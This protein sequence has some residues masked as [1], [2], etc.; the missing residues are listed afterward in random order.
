MPSPYSAGGTF[1][2]VLSAN[3]ARP[4]PCPGDETRQ[5][6]ILKCPTDALHISAP[7][8]NYGDG[9]G[10]AGDIIGDSKHHGG[11]DKA[12]YAFAREELDYWSHTNQTAAPYPNGHFGENLTTV[13][14]HWAQAV[15]GQQVRI[16]STLL[17]VSVPRQ[18]CRTFALWIDRP[19]WLKTF[20]AHG[21]CGCYFRV[22]EAGIIRA[23]D[24]CAFLPAPAHGITMGEAFRAK[25]GDK[26]AARRVYAAECLPPHHHRQLANL[27]KAE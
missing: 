19:N 21:D 9:S 13:G 4:Q 20:A 25:M 7:G 26:A 6:G 16:G 24:T 3:T 5:T 17:E 12:V 14:I 15:I 18:P 27:F 10:V 23:G 11:A 22:V 1:G 8:P 2:S